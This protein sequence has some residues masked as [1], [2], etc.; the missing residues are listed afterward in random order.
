MRVRV[1]V[2]PARA[3]IYHGDCGLRSWG[4]PDSRWFYILF[5]RCATES[6]ELN[7]LPTNRLL[8]FYVI[9]TYMSQE[10]YYLWIHLVLYVL[11]VR[12][13]KQVPK[14]SNRVLASITQ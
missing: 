12:L 7:D 9:N 5:N 13:S 4:L 8:S 14:N 3:Q 11:Y 1:V 2:K 10:R 6:E